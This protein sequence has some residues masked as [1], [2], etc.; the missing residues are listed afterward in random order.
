MFFYYLYGCILASD[1]EFPQLVAT[2][3][4]IKAPDITICS[5]SMPEELFPKIKSGI[6]YEF[7][8]KFSWL[9]NRTCIF[10]AEAGNKLVYQLK[11]EGK[12][13]RLKNYLLGFGM[14]M[15]FLQRG[16]MAIHCSALHNGTDAILIA[17]ESGSGKSTLTNSYLAA[18][19]KLMADDMVIATYEKEKGTMVYP[20]F[21]YQKLCRN[22]AVE[23]GYDL[24]KLIYINEQKDKFL[25]PYQG[26]FDLT[27]KPL[28]A[29]IMIGVHRGED[30]FAQEIKSI[31]KLRICANNLFLRHLLGEQ[32]YAPQI[33]QKC[34]E[35]IAG[36]DV[37]FVGRPEGKDTTEQTRKTVFQFI[38]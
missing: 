22:V 26:E 23:R 14:A 38:S 30:F 25:V 31:D 6:S 5:G 15:L 36:V 37:Y 11:P 4:N 18:G 20:A 32:K 7:G 28:K 9:Q 12:K 34:L 10:Y 1:T 3:K 35:L 19:W 24:N 27:E 21:P 2:E 29:F 8:E 16:K 33:G 13:T 17:G